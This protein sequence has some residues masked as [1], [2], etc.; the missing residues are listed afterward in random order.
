MQTLREGEMKKINMLQRQ[1][2]GG[3]IDWGREATVKG[4]RGEGGA[5]YYTG[6]AANIMQVVLKYWGMK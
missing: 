4:Q 3:L 6:E 2:C 5:R 1:P